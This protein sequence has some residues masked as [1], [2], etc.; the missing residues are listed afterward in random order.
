M[1][2]KGVG[3]ASICKLLGAEPTLVLLLSKL[4][5]LSSKTHLV[6]LR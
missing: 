6:F 2:E 1:K 3:F 4:L 5:Q